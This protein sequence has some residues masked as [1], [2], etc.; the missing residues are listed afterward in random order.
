MIGSGMSTLPLV[1]VDT[2]SEELRDES[3]FRGDRASRRAFDTFVRDWRD[4]VSTIVEHDPLPGK[5]EEKLSKKKLDRAMRSGSSL[6]A[7]LVHTAIEEF[8]VELADVIRCF[9]KLDD[10]RD[11]QRIVI[12][13]GSAVAA[14]A[15]SSRGGRR[16]SSRARATRSSW[17][18]T[19]LRPRRSRAG[20]RDASW[21]VRGPSRGANAMTRGGHRRS[22]TSARRTVR[23]RDRSRARPDGLPRGRPRSLALCRRQASPEAQ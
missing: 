10:W 16:C 7:G 2:Y 19:S 4:R 9:L 15:R 3:G 6:E 23:S 20:R 21:P 14:S 17:T 18:P 5:S 1:N 13:G 8:S 12:G 22:R 11:T